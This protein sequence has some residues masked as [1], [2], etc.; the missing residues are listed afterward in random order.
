MRATGIPE[1]FKSAEEV[2][3]LKEK[4][5]EIEE[6]RKRNHSKILKTFEEMPSKL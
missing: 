2:N 6:C 3:T 1:H 5:N 4:V